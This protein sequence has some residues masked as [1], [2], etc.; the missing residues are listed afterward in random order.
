MFGDVAPRRPKLHTCVLNTN[1]V[2][3]EN[4]TISREAI[5]SDMRIIAGDHPYRRP[6]PPPFIYDALLSKDTSEP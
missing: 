1:D 4:T 6:S 2:S 5:L 3:L